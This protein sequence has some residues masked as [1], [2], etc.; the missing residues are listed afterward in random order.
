[1]AHPYDE[2][3]VGEGF[4]RRNNFVVVVGTKHLYFG[5]LLDDF[6]IRVRLQLVNA[7]LR[8]TLPETFVLANV[9][10]IERICTF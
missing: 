7:Y 9:I 8:Q 6:D 4:I 5:A 3:E 1:M 2:G 10:L